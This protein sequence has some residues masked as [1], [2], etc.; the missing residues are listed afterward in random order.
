M[1]SYALMSECVAPH[2]GSCSAPCMLQ[3]VLQPHLLL[4]LLLGLPACRA[5]ALHRQC[6]GCAASG[7]AAW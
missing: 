3:H 1:T 5:A 7:A 6:V 4:P 2:G